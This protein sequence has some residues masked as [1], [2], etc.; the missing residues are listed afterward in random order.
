[1]RLLD[2]RFYWWANRVSSYLLLSGLWLLCA[3][4]IITL[5]PAT[6][7]MFA[8][9]RTWRDN[10]DDAFY[11][12]FLERLRRHL[13]GDVLLG[14][15]WLLAAA[16]LAL[17]ALL[18]AQVPPTVRVP[19]FALLVLG[20]VLYLAATVFIFPV[21]VSYPP[22]PWACARAS[23]VLGMTQLGTTALCL[24]VLLMAGV[25]F[26]LFPPSLLVTPAVAGHLIYGL[27]R[28]R[29]NHLFT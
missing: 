25:A 8:V 26:W 11:L 14:L 4:P 3:A 5:F 22:G 23:V 18:L 15:L 20:C 24:G 1:M 2:S 10:P 28:R 29:F 6:A 19:G 7:A 13:G 17:N 21:L 16:L 12:P 27:C 9:F